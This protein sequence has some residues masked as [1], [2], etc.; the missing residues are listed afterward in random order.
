MRKFV[1]AVLLSAAALSPVLAEESPQTIQFA[2]E[3]LASEEVS[4]NT[5]SLNW[6]IYTGWGIA[7]GLITMTGGM[8]GG[9]VDGIE[10]YL[11][12]GLFCS[13]VSMTL[14]ITFAPDKTKGYNVSVIGCTAGW[15]L[16]LLPLL[17]SV[18]DFY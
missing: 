12:G 13:I 6:L 7:S 2:L 14:S 8:I 1:L 11:P 17:T 10:G 15:L 9:L 5:E 16:C 18:S 4:V 3:P